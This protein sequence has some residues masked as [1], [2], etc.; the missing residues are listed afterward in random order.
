MISESVR[1]AI[2]MTNP[3]HCI[4]Y[5]VNVLYNTV[6]QNN[7]KAKELSETEY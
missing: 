1:T 4:R 6:Y 7:K 2:V 3:P 5:F